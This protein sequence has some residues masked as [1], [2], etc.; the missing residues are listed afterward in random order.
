VST[1]KKVKVKD[2]EGADNIPDKY[3]GK[4]LEEVIQMH[5][6]AESRLGVMGNDLGVQRK[7]TDRLL[8]L[9][10]ETDLGNNSSPTKVTIK[11]DELLE[12][13]TEALDRH[14][15]SREQATNLRLSQMEATLAA[16][17]FVTKH[18]DYHEYGAN[19]V[20]FQN[21]LQASP[22]RARAA[23]AASRGDWS[24]ADDLLTEFKS[25]K[26]TA[27]TDDDEGAIEVVE[28]PDKLARARNVQLESSSQSNAGARKNGKV[29]SRAA[30]MRL[31][32]EKP[33]TYYNDDFQVEITRAYAEGRVK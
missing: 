18:S 15:A 10:R 30:L 12:N 9:K 23:A 33:D 13:P 17:A 3:R 27:T 26:K 5:Q 24:A 11:S 8:D 4:T 22:L 21:W 6:Q 2:A 7:L 31:R 16:Q 25:A 29:Y 28:K 32:V 1:D 20:E 19:N 14:A